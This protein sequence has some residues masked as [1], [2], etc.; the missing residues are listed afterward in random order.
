MRNLSS[1][2]FRALASL[3]LRRL[4][5]RVRTAEVRWAHVWTRCGNRVATS[6]TVARSHFSSAGFR[7][8][9]PAQLT[10]MV[11]SVSS[12]T[13]LLLLSRLFFVPTDNPGAAAMAISASAAA[14]T[15]EILDLSATLILTM[16]LNSPPSVKPLMKQSPKTSVNFEFSISG[17]GLKVI[18]SATGDV[19]LVTLTVTM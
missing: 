11:V 14:L 2:G 19:S 5:Y 12:H 18:L 4:A 6:T 13:S 1:V 10:E 9:P 17:I 16:A 7:S 3:K 15:A 8:P